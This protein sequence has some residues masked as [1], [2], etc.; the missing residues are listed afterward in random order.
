MKGIKKLFYGLV[1]MALISVGFKIE[2]KAAPTAP[3]MSLVTSAGSLTN[4][5]NPE[6]KLVARISLVNG[7]FP[8][9]TEN[10]SSAGQ[11]YTATTPYTIKIVDT[12]TPANTIGDTVILNLITEKTYDTAVHTN[13]YIQIVGQERQLLETTDNDVILVPKDGASGVKNTMILNM[14]SG[15]T[16]TETVKATGTA[17]TTTKSPDTL[18]VTGGVDA[19]DSANT[20]LKI[21][22]VTGAAYCGTDVLAALTCDGSV[23]PDTGIYMLPQEIKTFTTTGISEAYTYKNWTKDN[24]GAGAELTESAKGTTKFRMSTDPAAT[25]LKENYGSLTFT[26]DITTSTVVKPNVTSDEFTYT[27]TGF[28]LADIAGVYLD[29]TT[30]TVTPTWTGGKFTFKA[31]LGTSEGV[32][33]LKIKM[34]AAA[35]GGTITRQFTVDNDDPVELD[36]V[37]YVTEGFDVLLSSFISEGSATKSVRASITSDAKSYAS[38]K[39]TTAGTKATNI[40]AIYV[41]GDSATK[42]TEAKTGKKHL[43]LYNAGGTT[44]YDTANITVYPKP[45]VTINP[46][47]SSSSSSSLNS[48]TTTSSSSTDTPLRV[49]LPIGV[50]HGSRAWS[51]VKRATVIFSVSGKDIEKTLDMTTTDSNNKL[52]K[53]AN[54]NSMALSSVLKDLCGSDSS[55]EVT[56]KAYPNNGSGYDPDVYGEA[57]FTAYRIGLD[58]T[59]GA[60]YTVNGSEVNDGY[61]YGVDGTTYTIKSTASNGGTLDKTNSGDF[62]NGE[63]ISLRVLGARTLKAVYTDKSKTPDTGGEGTDS[64]PNGLDPVPKTGESKTDIW[65]LW[66]VLLV[67]ILGAGFMIWKRFGLVR[68]IAQAEEEVAVAEH[69][70]KVEAEAKEKESKINMLKDLRNL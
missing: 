24:A 26:P 70:E 33:T 63:T 44:E 34:T 64:D 61:F 10:P 8:E 1:F 40:G 23:V 28:E 48:T 50:Y 19:T 12:T 35:G 25:V 30:T 60:K 13:Y 51:D 56:V 37:I 5:S 66:S 47:G 69:E 6:T 45:V 9:I 62:N 21:A 49:D 68:A 65:I 59:G 3:T 4:W 11:V 27:L 52:I 46:S 16:V 41:H 22:K 31:P 17:G 57:K 18:N 7:N 39:P 20:T 58:T 54:V 29:E 14:G 15:N 43:K 36:A 2:A 55:K 42:D 32:H 38:L 67:S 53:Y